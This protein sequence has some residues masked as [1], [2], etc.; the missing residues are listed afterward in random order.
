MALNNY[1]HVIFAMDYHAK[2]HLL[3]NIVNCEKIVPLISS[4]TRLLN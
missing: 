1:S 4:F 2:P 3:A